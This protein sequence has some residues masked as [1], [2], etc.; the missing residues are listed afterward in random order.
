M[1]IVVCLKQVLDT[2]VP[3]EVKGTV[4]Q[5][6]TSPVY[7]ISPADHVALEKAL[8]IKATLA[9]V[10]VTALTAGPAR[11][12]QALRMALASGADG[13][14]HLKDDLFEAADAYSVARALGKA[15]KKLDFDLILCGN[16]S[17]DIGAGQVPVFLAEMLCLPRVTGV[18]KMELLAP[19]RF[20]L[21]RRLEKGKRQIVECS[22]PAVLAV[23]TSAGQPRYVSEFSLKKAKKKP[24]QTLGL[25]DI[26]LASAEISPE[27]S[28]VK[29]ASLAP[30]KPRPKKIFTPG[31]KVSVSQRMSFLLSSVAP[32]KKESNLLEGATDYLAQQIIEYLTQEG[33]LPKQAMR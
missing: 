27:A 2:R 28:P 22:L 20:K 6:E 12:E 19:D 5:K 33:I 8:E 24:I 10:R 17:W 4:V 3:L 7:I 9:D 26:G 21:W 1:K 13:A 25:A 29:V 11:A 16:R 14:I 30:P 31:S 15:I 32:A 18:M 23:D